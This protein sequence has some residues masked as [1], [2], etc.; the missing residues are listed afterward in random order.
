MWQNQTNGLSILTL[1]V[2]FSKIAAVRSAS[3]VMGSRQPQGLWADQVLISDKKLY[4]SNLRPAL[5]HDS[6]ILMIGDSLS[7]RLAATLAMYLNVTQDE[8]VSTIDFGE[9]ARLREGGHDYKDWKDSIVP[10]KDNKINLA[11]K[12]CPQLPSYPQCEDRVLQLCPSFSSVVYFS[13]AFHQ[14]FY[15]DIRSSAQYPTQTFCA[16]NKLPI[17]RYFERVCQ[18]MTFNSQLIMGLSPSGDY[19]DIKILRMKRKIYPTKSYEELKRLNSKS[20]LENRL[21][22][23]QRFYEDFSACYREIYS[24]ILSSTQCTHVSVKFLDHYELFKNRTT[25]NMRNRGDSV[26]HLGNS[27]RIYRM[28][29]LLRNLY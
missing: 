4:P 23:I 21:K 12:W 11:F 18:S 3:G 8:M 22:N 17:I 15:A 19:S 14:Q 28:L 5:S 27:A 2:I 10:F 1:A 25:G 6:G 7:R 9:S 20:S 24:Y 29:D 16:K 13:S 26:Y